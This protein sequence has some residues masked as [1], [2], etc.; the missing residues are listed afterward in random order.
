MRAGRLA[1]YGSLLA[2]AAGCAERPDPST[3]SVDLDIASEGLTLGSIDEG[4]EAFGRI[5]GLLED[6]AGRIYVADYQASEVRVFAPDGRHLYSF[7]GEG[8]GPG[9][10]SGP[11]CL[12]WAPDGSLWIRDGGNQRYSGFQVEDSSA[13]FL[14]TRAMAHADNG[15]FAPVAFTAG[16]GLIDVGHRRKADGA[17]ELVRFVLDSSGEVTEAGALT[18][19]SVESLGG[20]TVTRSIQQGQVRYYLYQP[21]STRELVTHGP[22]GKWAHG[23]SSAYDI[24]L[25]Q[26]H[27][28]RQIA[29]TAASPRLSSQE[30][31]SAI[32]RMEDDAAR[33]GVSVNELPYGVPDSKPP[34]QAIFFDAVGRLWVELSQTDGR[35]RVAEVWNADGTLARRV[36][37]PG[38]IT[39]AH[40]GWVGEHSALGIRRDS[41]DVEHVV[42]LT[43]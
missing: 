10:L 17:Q 26:D 22:Q 35:P 18:R 3:A 40:P 28:N 43:F 16:G 14:S 36:Q 1:F 33:A 24:T 2:F 7:G 15:Y 42:R 30:R 21:F 32:R 27:S 39:L 8:A 19:A 31:A 13:T 9:E 20:H 29:G 23:I 5:T 25:R 6:P 38:D 34:L 37:W 12:A 41:L 11:C 4:P